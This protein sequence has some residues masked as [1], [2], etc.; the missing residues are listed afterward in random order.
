M[1]GAARLKW[2]AEGPT[3]IVEYQTRGDVGRLQALR[4]AALVA[5][6]MG[7]D[8]AIEDSVFLAAHD[9]YVGNV[10]DLKNKFPMERVSDITFQMEV[11]LL[12][13]RQVL[14]YW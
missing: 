13:L 14:N 11:L 1:R 2:T 10:S 3:G 5:R 4:G 6:E 8:A 7:V 9:S 12:R